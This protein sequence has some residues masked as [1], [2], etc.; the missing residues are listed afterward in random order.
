MSRRPPL[1]IVLSR[2][3]LQSSKSLGPHSSLRGYS[4]VLC[5]CTVSYVLYLIVLYC[6]SGQ[7]T[8]TVL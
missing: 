2:S 3:V 6:K 1:G 4:T 8:N 5:R 7:G